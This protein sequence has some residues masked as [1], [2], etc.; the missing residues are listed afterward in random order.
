[1]DAFIR[2][3]FRIVASDAS[4]RSL[5]GPLNWNKVIALIL[6]LQRH[7]R[8]PSCPICLE[9]C[10]APR[11]SRCGHVF[12][13]S[14]IFRHVVKDLSAPR[15]TNKCPLCFERV[16]SDEIKLLII[17]RGQSCR[18]GDRIELTLISKVL[19]EKKKFLPVTVG[20]KDNVHA[21]LKEEIIHLEHAISGASDQDESNWIS[22]TREFA[23]KDFD[24]ISSLCTSFTS[25]DDSGFFSN[26]FYQECN[27]LNIYLDA[28]CFRMIK[29][30]FLDSFPRKLE[31]TVVDSQSLVLD[32]EN[33]KRFRFLKHLPLFTHVVFVEVDLV[34]VVP[35]DIIRMTACCLFLK[36]IGKYAEQL[37]ERRYHR[38]LRVSTLESKEESDSGK[39]H[40]PMFEASASSEALPRELTMTT[41]VPRLI[42]EPAGKSTTGWA[43]IAEKGFAAGIWEPL[44]AKGKKM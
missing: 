33:K 5:E 39:D 10:I 16:C 19:K 41:G 2:S 1:V 28:L 7:E 6:P 32:E 13:F 38:L 4:L 25:T 12:C 35:E 11:V 9:E 34:G 31:V 23:E 20:V 8:S 14:C 43:K 21:Y 29:D 30:S 22:K 18:T 36:L 26:E 15:G 40:R 44:S 24:A 3:V 37:E 17:E 27:G 42:S